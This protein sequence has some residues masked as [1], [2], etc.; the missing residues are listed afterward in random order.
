MLVGVVRRRLSGGLRRGRASRGI[1]TGRA[2]QTSAVGGFFL[3]E[4][5]LEAGDPAGC[6]DRMLAAGGGPDL[7][8]NERL[9][10]PRWYL[11]LTRAELALGELA[12]AEGWAERAEAA[13]EGLGLPG[14]T[15]WA[16]HARAEVLLARGDATRAA[17]VASSAAGHHSEAGNRITAERCRVLHG[18]ALA[19]AGERE[20][21][22]ATL[23]SARNELEAFGALA[24][25][26]QAAR[27]LRRLGRRVPRSRATRE[28]DRPRLGSLSPRELEIAGL[29]HQGRTNKQIA[30][31]LHLSERTVETH[32]THAFRKLGV[33][34]RTALAAA[35]ERGRVGSVD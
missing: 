3:A 12:R 26:D 29:V 35:V 21:A 32:L 17:E 30:A 13:A 4:A 8:L 18:V 7:P 6:R 15:G 11:L 9:Y 34:R 20:V 14:R 27:E 31:A 5:Q 22:I 25:R 33:S 19:A 24:L 10:Q 28:T 16:E 23:E 1:S 2:D